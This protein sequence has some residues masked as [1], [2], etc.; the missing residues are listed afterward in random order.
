MPGRGRGCWGGLLERREAAWKAGSD[1]AG[2]GERLPGEGTLL[3]GW[4]AVMDVGEM[5]GRGRGCRGG[6]AAA[7]EGGRL[8][9]RVEGCPGGQGGH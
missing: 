8:L 6:K 7:S 3:R 9:G 5:Q 1:A 2:V 4:E